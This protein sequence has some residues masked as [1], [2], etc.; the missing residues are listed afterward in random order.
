[1]YLC[2]TVYCVYTDVVE[3][4][5]VMFLVEA[6]VSQEDVM[7]QAKSGDQLV[8]TVK[9]GE[10]V[11]Q[12]VTSLSK[13]GV[14]VVLRQRNNK[15]TA[16]AFQGL[17]DLENK[18]PMLLFR[19]YMK[20]ESVLESMSE[21]NLSASESDK[22]DG[23]TA[24]RTLHD[25][26]LSEGEKTISKLRYTVSNVSKRK[27]AASAANT[28]NDGLD[29]SMTQNAAAVKDLKMT[30]VTLKNFGPYGSREIKYP[31]NGRGLVLIRG[32]STDG[33]GADSNGAGKVSVYC[34]P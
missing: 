15:G 30:S 10:D 22:T 33:T 16:S 1:M 31:L 6:S 29:A 13:K 14:E 9:K 34:V 27:E 19:E 24:A 21:E 7:N 32:K 23:T 5:Y 11:E 25:H 18:D 17:R 12:L 20:S 4:T 26:V 8:L 3:Y 2:S 28:F